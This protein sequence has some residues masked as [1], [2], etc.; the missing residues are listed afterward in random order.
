MHQAESTANYQTGLVHA[1][2]TDVGMR[3]STNQDSHAVII[4]DNDALWQSRGHFFLVADGMGAHAAGELASKMAA[5]GISHRYHKHT[6]ISPPEALKLAIEEANGEIHRRG[7]ANADFHN[8]GTTC[9][10]LL[11]LPQ[12]AIVGHVGDSR[13]YRV[14]GPRVEQLSFDHSLQWELKATGQLPPGVDI[15]GAV[16]KNV[17][18]RSL[19]PGAHVQVDLEG[20]LPIEMGDRY[21]LCS[22]GL[23]GKVEDDEIGVV[24]N[25]M[26]PPEAARLLVDL[27]NLRGGPDNITCLVAQVTGEQISTAVARAEPLRLG[28]T[29]IPGK[30]SP[31]FLTLSSVAGLAAVV[32]AVM[33]YFIPA[34][35]AALLAI[36][37]GLITWVQSKGSTNGGTVLGQGRRLGK[38]PYA[39]ASAVPNAA[40]VEKLENVSKELREAT[41]EGGWEI[42]WKSFN[43]QCRAAGDFA[44]KGQFA[45]AVQAY[46]RA[47]TNMM[48][49]LRNQNPRGGDAW[50]QY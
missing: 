31:I 46:G 6:D 15:S 1:A 8:M 33:T 12:G 41:S 36:V 48:Q 24:L 39:A 32:L 11:L 18:T 30:V 50:I 34:G 20:P 29:K 4:A 35:V 22:D 21:L 42:D 44:K 45:P 17:I 2:L 16:P 28:A 27:A 10:S 38:G 37:G 5:E 47:I 13:V 23:T 26:M 14:R 49:Q 9:S 3:R 25:S 19:G 43:E 40:F 7:E